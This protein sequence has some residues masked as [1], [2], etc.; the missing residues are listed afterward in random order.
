MNCQD[1]IE[2]LELHADAGIF[3]VLEGEEF[4]QFVENIRQGSP[5][6]EITPFDDPPSG[7][8]RKILDG[9][10]RFRPCRALGLAPTVRCWRGTRE[11]AVAYAF[12]QIFQ[13][14]SAEG[15]QS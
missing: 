8:P 14:G 2:E 5:D 15:D 12:C 9:K 6:K 11:E 3:P 4:D 7:R 13:S 1:S 10:N